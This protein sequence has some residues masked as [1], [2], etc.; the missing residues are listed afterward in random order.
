MTHDFSSATHTLI[1]SDIHLSNAEPTHPTNPLWKLFKN[2]KFFIDLSLRHLVGRIQSEVGENRIE[3]ILDGDIFDFDSVLPIPENPPYKV[4]WLERQRGLNSEEEKS[5]YKMKMILDDHPVFLEV[6]RQFV[7]AGNHL[8]FVI[9]NHDLELHWPSVQRDI[10]DRLGLT[11]GESAQIRFVEWF[12]IS[13]RDTLVEHGNQYDAYGVCN[14]PINPLIRNHNSSLVRLPFG[15]LAG[16]YMLNGMGLMNPHSESSYIKGSLWEY[17]V[18]FYKYVVRTQPLIIWTWFWGAI[19]TLSV[20]VTEGLRPA[21]SDPLT[22]SDRVESIAEK[23]NASPKIVWSL[24]HLHAHPTCFNPIQTL[25]ELWLDRALLFGLLVFVSFQFFS[26][27]SVF[28][29]ASLWWFTIPL[30]VLLAP[31]IFYARSVRS[32]VRESQDAAFKVVPTVAKITHVKRVVHG[33]THH[34]HHTQTEG[35]EYLNPGTWSPAFRDPECKQPFG[36]RC[37]IW[38]KPTEGG[39]ARVAELYEWKETEMT[40][41]PMS[42]VPNLRPS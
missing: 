3:L 11:G 1:V 40:R 31:Y 33:H 25:Q 15:N 18:F 23:A 36:K 24:R 12:Y 22:I 14:N 32:E 7:V 38:I 13:N 35:I 20:T 28:F 17:G 5:R 29:T 6:L 10:V 30:M 39:G 42:P 8:I 2:R 4:G 37:F 21:L 27:L 19:V 9:G 41:I 26:F 34:A 16:K